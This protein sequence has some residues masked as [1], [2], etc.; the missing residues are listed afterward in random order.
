MDQKAFLTARLLDIFLGDWDRH[1]DQWRW[2]DL[3]KGKR[4]TFKAVPRDRDQVFYVNQGIFLKLLALPWVQPKFQG[5]GE[6]IKNINALSFNA[7]YIDG[8]FTNQVFYDVWMA[9]TEA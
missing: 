8:I 5:F 2:I 3:V 6:K 4:K 9:T 7:R 1:G